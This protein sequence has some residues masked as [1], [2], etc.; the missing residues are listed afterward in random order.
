MSIPTTPTLYHGHPIPAIPGL[1]ARS[2]LAQGPRAQD[3]LAWLEFVPPGEERPRWRIAPVL[4]RRDGT[5]FLGLWKRN[6]LAAKMH[7]V[8]IFRRFGPEDLP[9][10]F[11]HVVKQEA[12]R[13]RREQARADMVEIACAGCG[14][15]QRVRA[16]RVVRADGYTCGL[17]RCTRNPDFHLPRTPEG[18]VCVQELFAAGGFSGWTIR[19]A[20]LEERAAIARA[21]AIRAA[22]MANMVQTD[23]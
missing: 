3:H 8:P 17:G 21:R 23:G 18:C 14:R 12:A 1:V 5:I 13:R 4:G 15:T 22:G 7:L 11:A 6:R 16:C 2:P 19:P 9:A 20:T 10:A